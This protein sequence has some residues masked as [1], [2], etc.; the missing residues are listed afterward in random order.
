MVAVCNSGKRKINREG[1]SSD[2]IETIDYDYAEDG[3]DGNVIEKENNATTPNQHNYRFDRNATL[4]MGEILDDD[5]DSSSNSS[6]DDDKIIHS[7][8]TQTTSS[9]S[10]GGDHTQGNINNAT[11]TTATHHTFD[12]ISIT[13]HL[14]DNPMSSND[15]VS[16]EL[17][18]TTS[19]SNSSM[20]RFVMIIYY[21]NIFL[22][23]GNYILVMSHAVSAMFGDTVCL[24]IAGVIASVLM[25]GVSQLRTMSSL[26]RGVSVA[27]LV[28]FP[29]VFTFV[30]LVCATVK[31]LSTYRTWIHYIIILAF[32]LFNPILQ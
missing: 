29:C 14:F 32:S 31:D 15:S 17:R 12:F 11:S 19:K 22:V 7:G 26:G 25:V 28:R 27:S 16:H 6:H 23:L 5:C 9:L 2:D 21:T 13:S 18:A 30:S 1:E 10:Q 24:P 3:D 8:I 4:T 20:T